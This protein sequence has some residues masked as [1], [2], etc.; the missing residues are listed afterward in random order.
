MLLTSFLCLLKKELISNKPSF[1][2][3]G[4][5]SERFVVTCCIMPTSLLVMYWC[6]DATPYSSGHSFRAP[7]ASLSSRIQNTITMHEIKDN[8]EQ[9]K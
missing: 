2:F 3:G 4:E 5:H 6:K 7:N 9:V 8:G 1:T